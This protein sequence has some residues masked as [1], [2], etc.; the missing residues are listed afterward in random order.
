M[1]TPSAVEV[2]VQS[3]SLPITRCLLKLYRQWS[4]GKLGGMFFAA[5][6]GPS[7]W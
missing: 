3:L 5:R 7:V 6:R 2:L 4:P 1:G